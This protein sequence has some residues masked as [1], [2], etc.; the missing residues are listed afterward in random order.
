MHAR[1]GDVRHCSYGD[2]RPYQ[3][4]GISLYRYKYLGSRVLAKLPQRFGIHA[5]AN[6]PQLCVSNVLANSPQLFGKQRVGELAE[7]I[8]LTRVGELA[9]TMCKQSIGDLA[10]TIWLAIRRRTRQHL[11]AVRY[12]R[13]RSNYLQASHWRASPNALANNTHWRTIRTGSKFLHP[14][15]H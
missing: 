4:F 13:T 6:S 8:G 14:A 15:V 11:R 5:L 10:A 7:T 2:A 3:P 9:I 12:W 1:E